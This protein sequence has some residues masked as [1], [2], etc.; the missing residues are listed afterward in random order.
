M[1]KIFFILSASILVAC[2]NAPQVEKPSTLK[3]LASGRFLIGSSV[4]LEQIYERD[5]LGNEVLRN[6]FTAIVPE[7]CMKCAEIHPEEDTFFFDDADAYVDFGEKHGM[8]VIGHCLIWHSQ[9][10]PW[11]FVDDDG[12]QVSAEVLTERM[13]KHINTIVSRY[14][15]RVK[16]WDVVNEAILDDGSYRKSPFYEILGEEY[17]PLAFQFAH[18]ADPDAELYYNDYSMHEPAKRDAVVKLVNNLKDRGL[19]IDAIGMQG[20]MGM[21]WPKVN[22][23][24]KSMLAFANTGLEVMITEWDMSALPYVSSSANISDTVAYQQMLNPFPDGLPDSISHVWNARMR[25]FFDLFCKHSN[26]VKRVTCWGVTDG[27]SWKNDFPVKGR[28]D[29]ALLFDRNYQPKPFLKELLEPKEALFDNFIYQVDSGEISGNPIIP[30]CFPDPSVCRV[31]ED[32]YL[33]N[34]SFAFFPGVPIWHSTDLKNWTRLGNVLDRPSQLNLHSGLRI[35]GGIYAAD[36]EYNPENKLFYVITTDVD[37][38]GNFFVTTSDPKGGYWSDP[39]FLPEVG[40]I[41][42]SILFDNDGKAYIVN[43]DAPQGEVEYDGHRAIWIR[44]FDWREGKTLGEQKMIINKGVNPADK[45][46]WV[47]GP[48][49]YHFGDKYYLMAAEGGTGDWHSEVIFVSDSPFGPFAPCA[50]NPILTQRDLDANRE[51]KVTCTGH[52]DLVQTADNQWYAVFLGV[53]PYKGKHD[54][55]GRETFLLPIDFPGDQPI[56]LEQGKAVDASHKIYP[57]TPLWKGGKLTDDALFIRTPQS[58]SYSFDQKNNLVLRAENIAINDRRQPSAIGRW[59][60]DKCFTASTSV[61]FTPEIADDFAGMMMFQND[62]HN[63]I[64]GKSRNQ[65]GETVV[66]IVALCGGEVYAEEEKVIADAGKLYLR[67]QGNEGESEVYY[68]Y[69]YSVDGKTFE[70]MNSK[71]SADILSTATANCFTG[72]LVGIYAHANY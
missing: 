62:E 71:I 11:F 14:K 4:N 27:D 1:K 15:G 9:C 21:D 52:A 38:G 59:V 54:V 22:E 31:G 13:H 20:H 36:I 67:V 66:K 47:E 24:E 37:G 41:D 3:D 5:T 29:Y 40:G 26:I 69:S 43:N 48:H 45:P 30:G 55:M 65:N 42:P 35:S 10:A 50:V 70:T 18:E 53:R 19:R 64:F 39:T 63:V 32:Y 44:E 25:E 34:S 33:V 8:T 6:N 68:T 12:N 61:E 16:G 57:P 23:F 49:L 2:S 51:N 28:V 72:T 60:T 56:I 17:I 46:V 7:N 58:E